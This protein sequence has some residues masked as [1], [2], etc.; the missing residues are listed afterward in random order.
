MTT[1]FGELV[2][3]VGKLKSL[4]K[5]GVVPGALVCSLVVSGMAFAQ[6]EAMASPVWQHAPASE[7]EAKQYA[8]MQVELDRAA[9]DYYRPAILAMAQADLSKVTP[10]RAMGILEAMA[11]ETIARA[12]SR[13]DLVV[14]PSAVKGLDLVMGFFDQFQPGYPG[15][16]QQRAKEIAVAEGFDL[17]SF[18]FEGLRNELKKANDIKDEALA[19]I[20]EKVGNLRN[21]TLQDISEIAIEGK[22]DRH[23]TSKALLNGLAA[24]AISDEAQPDYAREGIIRE[25]NRGMI[26]QG[27]LDLLLDQMNREGTWSDRSWIRRTALS[28]LERAEKFA[29]PG[30][31]PSPKP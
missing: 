5:D 31:S 15:E 12:P 18:K 2:R 3:Q 25:V 10:D 21:Y 24:S 17:D 22:Y 8:L 30:N 20:A 29:A 14:G 28:A 7:I 19:Q 9:L 1:G 27:T 13:G 11:K 23:A 26:L 16:V 4:V 6:S